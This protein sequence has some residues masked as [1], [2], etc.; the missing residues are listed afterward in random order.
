MKIGE[1]LDEQMKWKKRLREVDEKRDAIIKK[2]G[3]WTE[4]PELDRLNEERKVYQEE[5]YD[6]FLELEVY[7]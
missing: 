7:D 6:I 3:F 4:N 2:E 5:L 1:L